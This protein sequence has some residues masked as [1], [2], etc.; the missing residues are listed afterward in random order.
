M[1]IS[2]INGFF[3]IFLLA[4]LI[5]LCSPLFTGEKLLPFYGSGKICNITL[6]IDSIKNA[7]GGEGAW[8]P[9]FQTAE[10]NVLIAGK[11]PVATDSV[12]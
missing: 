7:V 9:T 1:N 10:Y 11:D 3:K 6:N 8:N 2:L 12:A 5:C 4:L